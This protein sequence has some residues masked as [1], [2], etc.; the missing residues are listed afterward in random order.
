MNH[1]RGNF[2]EQKFPL[3]LPFKKLVSKG[4][5]SPIARLHQTERYPAKELGERE[6]EETTAFEMVSSLQQI[7]N[8]E[9]YPSQGVRGARGGRNYGV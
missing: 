7:L 4:I 3:A 1:A 5:Q 8:I 6:E 9:R 2:F